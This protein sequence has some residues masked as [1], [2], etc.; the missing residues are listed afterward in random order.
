MMHAII[1][2]LNSRYTT[3]RYD[4]TKRI[5]KADLAVL[6]EAMRLSA[7]SINSQ[8]WRFV[9]I[10][11]DQAKQRLHETFV[12][13]YQFNQS[14]ALTSSEVI[15]FAHN[16]AYTRENYA[17]V[18][19][20]GIVDGRTKPE[21]RESAF[22]GFVFA[23]MNTSESGDTSS[24]TKAQTYLALGNSLHTLARLKIDSTPLEGIDADLL[25]KEFA[26]ELGGYHCDVALAI[27]YQA[28]DDFNAK[29]PKSRRQASSVF[30][31]V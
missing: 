30:V 3:K 31:H 4:E 17:E 10:S 23:E 26:E 29:L 21:D 22:G 16:P 12:N 27:G 19:D 25:N 24:W 8:P 2:D 20:Q 18:L 5:P 14:K 9:V 1:E 13:K 11:S 15:L 28:E 7:S 6:F